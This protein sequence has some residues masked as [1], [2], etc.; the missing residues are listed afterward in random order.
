MT[1]IS[2]LLSSVDSAGSVSI[3]SSISISSAPSLSVCSLVDVTLLQPMHLQPG[4]QQL[5][6]LRQ[7]HL[8]VWQAVLHLHPFRTASTFCFARAIFSGVSHKT[9][10]WSSFFKRDTSWVPASWVWILWNYRARVIGGVGTLLASLSALSHTPF[11][12]KSSH[13][14]WVSQMSPAL[15][16]ELYRATSEVC[17]NTDACSW[18]YAQ[19]TRRKNEYSE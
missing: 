18:K 4:P 3:K 13:L 7:L 9:S 8:L 12:I 15:D 16:I 11:L 6:C 19:P 1:S 10:N 17:S 5:L 14:V 2:L